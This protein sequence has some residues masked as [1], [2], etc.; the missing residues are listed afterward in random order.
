MK[1][2]CV[3]HD[4][5]RNSDNLPVWIL[6]ERRGGHTE[7]K[8]E[9]VP[10]ARLLDAGQPL[11]RDR[12]ACLGAHTSLNVCFSCLQFLQSH[13]YRKAAQKLSEGSYSHGFDGTKRY[14]LSCTSSVRTVAR[15]CTH[16]T[17]HPN[18]SST[19]CSLT[20]TA[21]AELVPIQPHS[22]RTPVLSPPA[23]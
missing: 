2:R 15:G 11:S 23:P 18:I 9:A 1:L 8:G 7:R 19:A 17:A 21:Q 12:K 6:G 20:V 16:S 3:R 22:G 5:V 10:L 13:G 14:I 4:V